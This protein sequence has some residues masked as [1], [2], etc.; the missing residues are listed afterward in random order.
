MRDRTVLIT[1]AT[2]GIGR[3]AARGLAAMG[4]SLALVGRDE[5]RLA[6]AREQAVEAGSPE[7]RTFRADISS[8]AEVRRLAGEVL[9]AIPRLDVL[10]NN[11]GTIVGERRTT[12]DGYEY[13]F[14]LDHLS[15][16]LL[17][18]LLLPRLMASAPSRVVTVSSAA[19]WTGRMHFD[20]LMLERGYRPFRAYCQAKLANVLFTYELARRQEGT[21]V[22]ANCLHP[23][24]VRTDFG[25]MLRGASRLGMSI[26]RPFEIGPRRG[27]RTTIYLAS[28]P[29]VQGVTG[30]YFVGRRLAASSPASHSSDDARK[31]W[32]ASERLTGLDLP[33]RPGKDYF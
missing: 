22:T 12:A 32:E 16:F 25:K 6:R 4:A 10:V 15:P 8:M 27:A 11:A 21:G 29:D 5:E 17:T 7:V 20:D 24:A 23:G 26:I 1:G 9:E 30:R 28:S 2:G 18:N 13:T 31:L 33:D 19:H 3:E 14:A